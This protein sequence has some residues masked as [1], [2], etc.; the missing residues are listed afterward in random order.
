M[1]WSNTPSFV[2]P[3]EKQCAPGTLY[4][5]TAC[6]P[7]TLMLRLQTAVGH[8]LKQLKHGFSGFW[9]RLESFHYGNQPAKIEIQL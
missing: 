7:I 3:L 5:R 1:R 8:H 4:D 9:V 2:R 6:S